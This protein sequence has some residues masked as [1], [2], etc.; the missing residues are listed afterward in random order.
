MVY[1]KPNPTS[2]AMKRSASALEGPSGWDIA[3]PM[4]A[5]PQPSCHIPFAHY[6]L[7]YVDSAGKLGCEESASIMD[8]NITLFTPD[9]RQTF[10]ETLG[11]KI[12]FHQPLVGSS[13]RRVR[14][15]RGNAPASMTNSRL[16]EDSD[17]DDYSPA[18]NETTSIRVGD[19][20]KLM[21]YYEGALKHFQQLNCRMVA[22]AFIK[23]IE[24]RKQVRHP[25]NG[26][27]PPA[28]SAPGTTGDPEK[29]KPEWWPPGVMHKEPDH[30]RKEYRIE[31]LLHIIRKL[32]S[33]GI[34]A[35]KLKEV[36]CDTKR[37]LKHPS[38]VDIILEVLRVRKMEERWERG[39]IDS[40]TLVYVM[41]RGPS[42][43]GDEEEDSGE[44]P[45]LVDL[46]H[47]DDGLL[48]PSSSV[49]QTATL[50]TP[51][52][53]MGLPPRSLPGSFSLAEPLNFESRDRPFYATPPQYTD[54]F[55]Q[56]ML[57]TP[58]TA[59]MVSPHDVSVFS[60]SSQPSYPTS[61]PDQHWPTP[62]FR[63]DI[64]NPVGYN[65]PVTTQPSMPYSMAMAPPSHGIHGLQAHETPL[66]PSNRS[67]PFRTGSLGHP[68]PHGSPLAHLS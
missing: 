14:R 68:H 65:T 19:S 60:Y 9:V 35:D 67:L 7:I 44:G 57:S 13:P 63:Q 50:T 61:T 51:I 30:L 3:P 59:E 10:L 58:V 27:K 15:R 28:G 56:G 41:N 46:E 11:E 36:A 53:T 52:D 42:P 6:A 4:M 39:E 47:I 38:H 1:H 66:D 18:G 20:N 16:A 33:Y 34:T 62:T 48:T 22:K 24:P 12:G 31:L 29:T 32:G 21:N 25:Y 43:K 54:A 2:G 26:G 64:F 17:S 8:Q 55:S 40:S 5:A 37:S 45:A 49:E 23:F